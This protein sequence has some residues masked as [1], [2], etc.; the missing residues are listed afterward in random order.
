MTRLPLGVRQGRADAV[1]EALRVAADPKA[2]VTERLQLIEIFGEVAQP[3]SVPVLL[4][5]A[6]HDS[7]PRI[8]TAA[9]ASLCLYDEPRIGTSVVALY[10]RLADD[11][12]SA[13]ETLL[14]T[15]KKWSRELPGSSGCR[16]RRSAAH[17]TGSRPQDDCAPRSPD[18]RA[19]HASI[20]P[21]S[22]G[23]RRPRCRHKLPAS[24]ACSSRPP[25]AIPTKG[26][27]SSRI[28]VR[29]AT[30]FSAKGADRP[31]SHDL[32]ARRLAQY[33]DQC[34][35]SQRRDPRRFRA[36]DGRDPR[37]PRRRADCGSIR[38]RRCSSC[39]GVDGQNITV[40]RRDIEETIPQPKSS[41]CPKG[42][43]TG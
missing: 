15:R 40:V 9:L 6:E 18:C 38:I 27:S 17:Q 43:S 37:R 23:Q 32:Q 30:S 31:R 39:A 22:R 35:Q 2:A 7:D 19:D 5:L 28:P 4:S 36:S 42:C 10:P 3:S 33:A 24:P 25:A 13:A 14:S 34:R 1:A 26:N 29:S 21:I 8:K 12:Q 16:P 20:S 11:A 41:A